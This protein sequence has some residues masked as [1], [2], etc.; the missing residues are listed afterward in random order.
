MRWKYPTH[1]TKLYQKIMT[2][3]NGNVVKLSDNVPGS[4]LIEASVSRAL[5][6][7]SVNKGGEREC[8]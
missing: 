8:V 3:M 2:K 6:A 5:K 4:S 1:L 7:T